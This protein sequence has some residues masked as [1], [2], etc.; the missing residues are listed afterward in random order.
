M[1]LARPVVWA[2][3]A[4]ALLS[5]HGGTGVVPKMKGPGRLY[6]PYFCAAR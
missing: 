6:P 1:K 3:A 5:W 4:V 2:K